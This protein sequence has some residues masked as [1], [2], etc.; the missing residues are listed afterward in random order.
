MRTFSQLFVGRE[1][2]YGSYA[3]GAFSP[4]GEKVKV[5]AKTTHEPPTQELYDA[6]LAGETP[7][8]IVPIRPDGTVMW[9]AIDVDTYDDEKLHKELLKKVYK[10]SLPLVMTKSKSGGAHL[11]CFF[12]APV[13]AKEA[14]E[15]AKIYLRKL[16]LPAGT[17]IFPKQDKV[18]E[19]DTGSWINLPYFGDTRPCVKYDP[20]E[21]TT[22]EWALVEDFVTEANELAVDPVD[23]RNSPDVQEAEGESQAPPCI[24]RMEEE[25]VGEGGR[26]EALFH[27]AT[28][29]K[30]AFP[31]NWQNKLGEWNQQNCEPPLPF[32]DIM[33]LAQQN[34]RTD[35]GY[36]CKKAPMCNLCDRDL[37]LTRKFGIG[38]GLTGEELGFHIDSIRKI[39]SEVPVYWV[40]ID[41]SDAVKMMAEDLLSFPRFKKVI[42]ASKLNRVLSHVKPAQWNE[43]LESVMEGVQPIKAPEMT[44]EAGIIIFI[45]YDWLGQQHQEDKIEDAKTGIPYYSN[46]KAYFRA[47]DLIQRVRKAYPQATLQNIWSVLESNN[48]EEE[49]FGEGKDSYKL[50]MF[51]CPNL[52]IRE[53]GSGF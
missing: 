34:E 36:G 19:K 49:T 13:T 22:F 38:Q 37:C 39:E 50:W 16:G 40:S 44:G 47:A 1:D 20:V 42:F 10:H 27:T 46:G 25:K 5:R 28:Y 53:M 45:L 51:P 3:A 33:R 14:R 52:P 24:D 21:D 48:A 4:Q 17:E 7:L 18:S 26:D 30:K 9:F 11:W 8:G 35:F 6:H 43:Y 23:M 32:E 31:D 2:C 41:G 15:T 29:M 12:T